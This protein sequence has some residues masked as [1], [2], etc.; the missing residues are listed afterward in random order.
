MEPKR[1]PSPKT[2]CLGSTWLSLGNISYIFAYC[3]VEIQIHLT[4]MLFSICAAL[5]RQPS[6]C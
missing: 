1:G 4:A 3:G 5:Q 2:R 6:P